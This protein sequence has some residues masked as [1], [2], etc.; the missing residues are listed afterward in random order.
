MDVKKN[1]WKGDL[2][3]Y[4][5]VFFLFL[6]YAVAYSRGIHPVS[7][8]ISA[9]EKERIEY[10]FSWVKRLVPKYINTVPPKV[11]PVSHAF[12]VLGACGGV[13]CKVEGWYT[14]DGEVF[15]DK[16]LKTPHLEEILFHEFV[17]H[18]QYMSG[19]FNTY[20]CVDSIFRE[21]EAYAAKNRYRIEA[22]IVHP[23]PM[24]TRVWC[25]KPPEAHD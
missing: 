3:G 11:T 4:T 22:R 17:H 21:R 13:E 18:Q 25:N 24:N 20:S 2:P 5:V 23:K 19:F 12:I 14:D 7:E 16:E 8:P 10:V 15:I 6:L 9:E 1:M